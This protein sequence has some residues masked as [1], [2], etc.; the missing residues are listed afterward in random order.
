MRK[1]FIFIV[2]FLISYPTW[3]IYTVTF[4]KLGQIGITLKGNSACFYLNN[5]TYINHFYVFPNEPSFKF[6]WSGKREEI[7][8]GQ[9]NC[10]MTNI[11]QIDTPYHVNIQNSEGKTY[12]DN[13][14]IRK[15]GNQLFLSETIINQENGNNIGCSDKTFTIKPETEVPQYK[16]K[17]TPPKLEPSRVEK[18]WLWLSGLFS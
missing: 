4:P 5:Q 6:D 3:A 11:S 10:M 2:F 14:C 8:K 18:I 7:G 13:F 1:K 9:A 12:L 17:P 16:P 15:K